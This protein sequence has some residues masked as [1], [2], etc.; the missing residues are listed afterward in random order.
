[1]DFL[2]KFGFF[3]L[4]GVSVVVWG[5]LNA[6]GNEYAIMGLLGA[7]VAVAAGITQRDRRWGIILTAALALACNAYLLKHKLDAA[8]GPSICSINATFDCDKV[9]SSDA[10]MLAGVPVTVFGVGFYAGLIIA[11]LTAKKGEK[12]EGRFDQA[13]AIFSWPAVVFSI[14][15]AY[16]SKVL[17]AFCVMCITI[18]LSNLILWFAGR[19]GLKQHNRSIT[20]LAGFVSSSDTGTIVVVFA[21]TFV[22]LNSMKPE[23]ASKPK[24]DAQGHKDYS[25]LYG[26][27]T[28]PVELVGNEPI[29]GNPNAPITVVEYADYGCPH[30]AHAWKEVKGLLQA[31]PDVRIAYKY[32]PRSSN[33]HPALG[34][35][36]ERGALCDATYAAEC[37]RQQDKFYEMSTQLFT[38]QGAFAPEQLRFMA[39]DIGLD[40]AKFETCLADPATKATVVAAAVSGDAAGVYGTPTLFVR[41]LVGDGWI[42]LTRGFDA[43]IQL[44][45]AK[46]DHV[47]LPL[48]T[49]PV[50][51]P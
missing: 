22:G 35:P 41:G 25:A 21:I 37:A 47:D 2:S 4:A 20:D 32:F 23:D 40:M 44:A 26:K 46:D 30:C 18:Y 42:Q 10:S 48:P 19:Q 28:G 31:R 14:Y 16:E 6:Q 38:N 15:L 27:P 12:D 45:E 24:T 1:M 11:G 39:N 3:V 9:N 29:L 7:A 49:Q 8:A 50:P 13:V 34:E 33:C 36:D 43:V 17:G 51:D 5:V